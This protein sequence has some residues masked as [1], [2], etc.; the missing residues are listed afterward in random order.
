MPSRLCY[1]CQTFSS[2][3]R[4]FVLYNICYGRKRTL[5]TQ[6]A[7]HQVMKSTIA[8]DENSLLVDKIPWQQK[9][10]LYIHWPYCK[11][12]CTYC[13]FNKYINTNIDPREMKRNLVKKLKLY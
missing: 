11:K 3:H 7:G 2:K 12:R 8:K 10:S 4:I 5:V 1:M 13:N 6:A 9:A